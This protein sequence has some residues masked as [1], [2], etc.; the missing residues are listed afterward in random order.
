MGSLS[1]PTPKTS[2][3]TLGA[4]VVACWARVIHRGSQCRA[5][6]G[7]WSMPRNRCPPSSGTGPLLT[8]QWRELCNKNK[9][10]KLSRESRMMANTVWV[11]RHK[12]IWEGLAPFPSLI[13]TPSKCP[14]LIWFTATCNHS[15][16]Q[17]PPPA[18]SW[19]VSNHD[20]D[21]SEHLSSIKTP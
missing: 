12:Q 18:P 19:S 5:A 8:H 10:S 13:P 7:P 1:V 11:G 2:M 21:L 14:G 20:P 15:F 17:H 16:T 4:L 6:L 3:A 9:L